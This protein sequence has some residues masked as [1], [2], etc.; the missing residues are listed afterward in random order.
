MCPDRNL[1]LTGFR[2]HFHH[3]TWLG[4]AFSCNRHGDDHK[5][6]GE[7]K[8]TVR[9]LRGPAAYQRVS[10]WAPYLQMP[11]VRLVRP[12]GDPARTVPASA[13]GIESEAQIMARSKLTTQQQLM[14]VR[15]ALESRRTPPQ[16]KPGLW[17]RAAELER[18][19][20]RKS[21]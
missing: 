4:F 13:T 6:F 20:E 10:I 11:A 17:R 19:I 16:L 2:P 7:A 9:I 1:F 14:G 15:A 5:T 8:G 18:M 3:P 21:E 12:S